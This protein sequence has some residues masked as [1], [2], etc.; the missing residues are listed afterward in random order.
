MKTDTVQVKAT[1]NDIIST[2]LEKVQSP[3]DIWLLSSSLRISP[4]T[5]L[6]KTTIM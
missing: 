1:S 3:F 2:I 5:H 4:E 6:S